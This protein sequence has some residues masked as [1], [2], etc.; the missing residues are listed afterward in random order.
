MG[1]QSLW[2]R[3]VLWSYRVRVN[4]LTTSLA[5]ELSVQGDDEE[6][7]LACWWIALKFEEVQSECI[8]SIARHVGVRTTYDN[9]LGAEADV[10][11]RVRFAIP[12]RTSCRRLYERMYAVDDFVEAWMYA[13]LYYNLID[14]LSTQRWEEI[15]RRSH[16]FTPSVLRRL[17]DEL[18]SAMRI[19]LTLVPPR[20]TSRKRKRRR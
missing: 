11:H 19:H 20:L 8:L 5:R 18:P 13:L 2:Q 16:Y 9:M 3:V 10:L 12:Y 4:P 6:H 1:S 14:L 17:Y 7:H 15:I